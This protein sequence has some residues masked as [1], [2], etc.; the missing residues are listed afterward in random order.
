MKMKFWVKAGRGV[1][2]GGGSTEHPPTWTPSEFAP[3]FLVFKSA[4]SRVTIV[5]SARE[6]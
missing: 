3:D 2:G 6:R 4:L 5:Y 1:V